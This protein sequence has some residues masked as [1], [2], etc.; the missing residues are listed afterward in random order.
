VTKT[1]KELLPE[2]IETAR[3]RWGMLAAAGAFGPVGRRRLAELLGAGERTARDGCDRL[4]GMGL[5]VAGRRGLRLTPGGTEALRRTDHRA[6]LP[7]GCEEA[8]EKTLRTT[9]VVIAPCGRWHETLTTA[10]IGREAARALAPLLAGQPVIAVTGGHPMAALATALAPARMGG[11]IVPATTDADAVFMA[12]LIAGR[13]GAAFGRE[14]KADA[15]ICA[16]GEPLPANMAA[17]PFRAA[18]LPPGEPGAAQTACETLCPNILFM[19]QQTA[20]AITQAKNGG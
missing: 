18:L 4:T 14:A 15:L 10:L 5:V 2:T 13:L 16:A 19:D 12:E 6:L 17:I 3:F 1:F 9:R 20:Q 8:A 11:L 7:P